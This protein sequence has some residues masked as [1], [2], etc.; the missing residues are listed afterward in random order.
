MSETEINI[1]KKHHEKTILELSKVKQENRELLRQKQHLENRLQLKDQ[2]IDEL[3]SHIE[4]RNLPDSKNPHNRDLSLFQTFMGKSPGTG[5][6]Y[7]ARVLSLIKVYQDQK[8][9]WEEESRNMRRDLD[10]LRTNLNKNEEEGSARKQAEFG[11]GQ[12]KYT[13]E[14]MNKIT[15]IENEN[16]GLNK[17][18]QGLR[19]RLEKLN[20]DRSNLER[21][22]QDLKRK[23][24]DLKN[25]YYAIDL[26]T[27]HK[28]DTAR[29]TPNSTPQ[30]NTIKNTK[31]FTTSK[32][33]EMKTATQF[34]NPRSPNE[35]SDVSSSE[36][37]KVVIEIMEIF[38][39]KSPTQI[40]ESIRKTEKVMQAIPKLQKLL[41]EIAAIV[42]ARSGLQ[43]TEQQLEMII[44]CLKDWVT[45]LEEFDRL[46]VFKLALIE[47]IGLSKDANP[48]E[49]VKNVDDL[50]YISYQHEDMR[51]K[52]KR[53]ANENI[54]QKAVFEQV[55]KMLGAKP[56]AS[57]LKQM[58]IQLSDLRHFINVK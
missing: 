8:E 24:E 27:P 43:T 30:S 55:T 34:Y 7:D 28:S 32:K 54:E 57:S 2:E 26:G 46:K 4:P 11:T 25:R 13:K 29:F 6:A 22:H 44:P 39:L 51:I 1:E 23:Y 41:S 58:M 48:S 15:L 17:D 9:Q 19:E 50:M 36:S 33:P 18:N 21:D 37:K 5:N 20:Y 3:K 38:N 14:L 53:D 52:T 42:F 10:K 56:T 35:R 12:D 47:K 16:I 31:S 49:I 45:E 40:V